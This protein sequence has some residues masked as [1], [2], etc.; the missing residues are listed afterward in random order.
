MTQHEMVVRHV[1]EYGY[2]NVLQAIGL[3]QITQLGRV[4][5]DLK[6]TLNAMKSE[7]CP[8]LGHGFVRY[9]PDFKKRAENVIASHINGIED[10]ERTLYKRRWEAAC[11][12]SNLR[13]LADQEARYI[14]NSAAGNFPK[15]P[16][17][18]LTVEQIAV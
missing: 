12:A 11:L 4:I 13:V 14:D 8:D 9:I 2:I 5:Y 3:Y 6:D 17:V 15:A 1:K 16:E 7:P 18:T 10:N